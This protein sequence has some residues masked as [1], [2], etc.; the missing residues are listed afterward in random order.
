MQVRALGKNLFEISQE[1]VDVE[2]PLVCLVDN[3][4]VI[5]AE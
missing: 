2:T 5:S 4:G 3:D 1:E